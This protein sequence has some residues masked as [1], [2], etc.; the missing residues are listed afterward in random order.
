MPLIVGELAAEYM[1][2]ECVYLSQNWSFAKGPYV[3]VELF[4]LEMTALI[5][6]NC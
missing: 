1:A 5:S 6:H 4:S 3:L 2:G